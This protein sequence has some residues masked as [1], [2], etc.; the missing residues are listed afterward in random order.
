MATARTISATQ[1]VR[2]FSELL[3]RVG[4]GR[5]EI[6]IQRYRK[7]VAHL[8]PASSS[9]TRWYDLY[10]AVRRNGRPDRHLEAD[11]AASRGRESSRSRSRWAAVSKTALL[12]TSVLVRMRDLGSMDAQ[13]RVCFSSAS[14]AEICSLADLRG[15]VFAAVRRRYIGVLCQSAPCVSIDALVAGAVTARPDPRAVFIHL[16]AGTAIALDWPVLTADP[17][18]FDGLGAVVIGV[19]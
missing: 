15:G 19:D 18:A 16:I 5:E 11:L 8:S 10:R 14:V 1:A 2:E 9:P 13:Q 17:G 12:D 6:V 4:D 3:R 7:P